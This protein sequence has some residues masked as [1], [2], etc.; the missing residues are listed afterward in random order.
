M[1]DTYRKFIN[2][3]DPWCYYKNNTSQTPRIG[4]FLGDEELKHRSP[5]SFSMFSVERRYQS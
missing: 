5:S 2:S 3:S 4:L 1:H